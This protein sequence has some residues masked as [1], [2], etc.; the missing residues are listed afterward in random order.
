MSGSFING[1]VKIADEIL[2]QIAV[3]AASDVYGVY[4]E[5]NQDKSFRFHKRNSKSK[6][7]KH[8]ENLHFTLDVNFD[9]N[10]NVRKTVKKIQENVKNTVENM[11]GISVTR[12]DV[13]VGNLEI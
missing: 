1:S 9:R 12:V 13:N 5:D 2:D 3:A 6:V 10:I 11:T 4:C 7:K 8:G